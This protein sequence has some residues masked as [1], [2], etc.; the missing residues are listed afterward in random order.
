MFF[1][2]KKCR[3]K[4]FKSSEV[5]RELRTKKIDANFRQW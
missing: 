2:V 4:K 1:Y 3:V 5:T